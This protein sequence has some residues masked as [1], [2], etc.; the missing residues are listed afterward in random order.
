MPIL[1]PLTINK[2]SFAF[3]KKIDIMDNVDV[4]SFFINTPLEGA[5]IKTALMICFL[6]NPKLII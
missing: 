1:S 4:E 3:A 2:D 6:I 5:M